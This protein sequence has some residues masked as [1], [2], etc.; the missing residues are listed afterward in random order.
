MNTNTNEVTSPSISTISSSTA[1][2]SRASFLSQ[3]TTGIVNLEEDDDGT[4]ASSPWFV[5]SASSSKSHTVSPVWNYFAY[6]DAG[7]HPGMKTYR[8]C[9]LCFRKQIQKKIDCTK[10][11]TPTPLVNHL[12][13]AHKEQY[14]EYVLL[15]NDTKKKSK[16]TTSTKMKPITEHFLPIS[17]SKENFNRKYAKWIVAN[18]MPLTTGQSSDFK[19]MIQSLSKAVTPPDYRSTLDML[20]SG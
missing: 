10:H 6:F 12:R 8:I 13:S 9:L 5:A 7:H 4:V 20:S 18:N 2:G 16:I 15:A 1:G 14:E 11:Y 19:E 17:T 3:S